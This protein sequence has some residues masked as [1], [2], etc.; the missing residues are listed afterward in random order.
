MSNTD[1]SYQNNEMFNFKS[2]DLSDF[3][4]QILEFCD[5]EVVER[6]DD[7][8]VERCD[9]EVVERCDDE[10]VERCDDE[11]VERCDDE[12]VEQYQDYISFNYIQNINESDPDKYKYVIIV[13]TTK[14]NPAFLSKDV[15][16][17]DNTNTCSKWENVLSFLINCTLWKK[18]EYVWIPDSQIVIDQKQV[19]R[20]FKTIGEHSVTIG[21]PSLI[22][23]KHTPYHML[24]NKQKLQ[25]RKISFVESMMPCFKKEFIEN[26]LISFLSENIGFLESGCGIDLWWSSIH[27]KE[28]FVI[29]T[30][31][32][33]HELPIASKES[34]VIERE[35]FINKY[36]LTLFEV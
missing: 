24:Y 19:N 15:F 14:V 8:V 16:V 31:R 27:S 26:Y 13:N 6:C 3:N 21:Q 11:V 29:D 7:E 17:L 34:C 22:N 2:L 18:Y 9:D 25:L 10:V 28:L 35:H 33:R 20:F 32:I 5:D 36:K 1:F 12:V 23:K 30:I 4:K